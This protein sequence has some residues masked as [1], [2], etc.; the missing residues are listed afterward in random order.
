LKSIV[1][2]S[3]LLFVAECLAQEPIDNKESIVIGGI[4][5]Y[6]WFKGNDD[7]KPVLLF[8]HGGPGNSVIPY[9]KKFSHDLYKHFVVVHWD[10][11]EAGQTARLNHSLEPLTFRLFK[12]DTEEIVDYLLARFNRKKIFLVGHSWG[13]A[14]GFHMVKVHPQKLAAF[15]GIGC[16]VNQLESE[17]IALQAMI[18]RASKTND[19]VARDEFAKIAIPFESGEQLFYH[20][21]GLFTLTGSKTS[22]SKD[23]V[24]NWSRKWLAVFNEAS[25]ENL[26]ENLPAVKCPIFFLAGRNDMQTNSQLVMKYFDFVKADT[27]KFYWFENAGHNIPSAQGAK[28]QAIIINEVLPAVDH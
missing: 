4:K 20:R 18:E 21:Q 16:M 17:R 10:Q 5:Q 23:F 7:T 26:F 25:G 13:T 19:T 22:L 9:A 27:K 28:L 12:N 15:I 24:I 14:L 8:L 1:T 6:I 11:R 3:V 2:I